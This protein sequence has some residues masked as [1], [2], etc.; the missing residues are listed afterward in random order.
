MLYKIRTSQQGQN[1]KVGND[2][3]YC[4][5]PW[6]T[7]LLVSLKLC[8]FE[9]FS[10][11]PWYRSSS[12]HCLQLKIKRQFYISL[13]RD[14]IYLTARRRH[15]SRG[16]EK[17]LLLA[18]PFFSLSMRMMLLRHSA[19]KGKGGKMRGST[20]PSP[21]PHPQIYDVLQFR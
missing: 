5:S 18:S 19:Q 4:Y 11:L 12:C 3:I 20:P 21:P 15:I 9:P 10:P 17:S 1:I 13:Y 6:A 16:R 2:I 7:F 8:W 14:M